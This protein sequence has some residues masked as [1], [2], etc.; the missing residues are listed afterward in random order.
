MVTEISSLGLQLDV[1]SY[2][3]LIEA[4]VEDPR[5]EVGTHDWNSILHAFCKVGR[6]ED[7]RRTFKRMVFLQFEPNE[8]T[9]VS[10]INGYANA[11]KYFNVMMLWNEVK[12]RVSIEGEKRYKQAFMEMH[13]KLKVSK[14]RKRNFRK[15]E[16]LVGFKNWAGLNA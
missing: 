9:Y 10:L 3:S 6:K 1:G 12:R 5:I 4:V 2:N 14:L 8:Q 16:A 15:M 7:A 13:K 11:G